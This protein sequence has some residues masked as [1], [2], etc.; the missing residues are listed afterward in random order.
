MQMMTTPSQ[1]FK[2]FTKP[3]SQRLPYPEYRKLVIEVL[4][5]D[6]FRCRKC[7]VRTGLQ[8]HHILYRSRGGGDTSGNLITLCHYCHRLVHDAKLYIYAKWGMSWDEV[9]AD[10]GVTFSGKKRI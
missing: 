3:P 6:K 2:T 10:E 9:D 4:K 8:P 1:P 7:N 5:R